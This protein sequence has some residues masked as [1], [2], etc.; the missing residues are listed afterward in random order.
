M[1]DGCVLW[2]ARVIVPN[3][4]RQGVMLQLHEGHLGITRV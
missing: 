3:K 1:L 4:N 2:G